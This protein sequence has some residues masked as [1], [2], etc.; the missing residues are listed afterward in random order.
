MIPTSGVG[1]GQNE[2][3]STDIPWFS[4]E[5]EDIKS[6]MPLLERWLSKHIYQHIDVHRYKWRV[7]PH[8]I[9]DRSRDWLSNKLTDFEGE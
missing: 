8:S 1:N 6:T 3:S 5:G 2:S 9:V 7:N 4:G